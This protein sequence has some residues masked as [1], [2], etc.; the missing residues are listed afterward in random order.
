MIVCLHLNDIHLQ[1]T[2][3]E[4]VDTFL[5]LAAEIIEFKELKE[6]VISLIDD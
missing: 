6:W 5:A 4:L 2:Q 1:Y 3:K